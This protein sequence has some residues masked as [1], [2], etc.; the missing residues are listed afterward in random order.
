MSADRVTQIDDATQNIQNIL[1][2]RVHSPFEWK[3]D[4][5]DAGRLLLVVAAA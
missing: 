3:D 1:Q 5:L 4:L 2:W